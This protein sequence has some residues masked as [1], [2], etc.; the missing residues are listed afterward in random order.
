MNIELIYGYL[1]NQNMFVQFS[2]Y[3]NLPLSWIYF[4]NKLKKD[5]IIVSKFISTFP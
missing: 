5:H 3:L 2:K 1:F 4:W